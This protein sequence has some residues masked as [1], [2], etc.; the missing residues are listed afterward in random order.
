MRAHLKKI[1]N[2]VNSDNVIGVDLG[3]TSTVIYVKGKGIQLREPSVVSVIKE[4]G[5]NIPYLFGQ[6]AEDMYGKTPMNITVIKPMQDGVIAD[7]TMAQKMIEHFIQKAKAVSNILQKPTIIISVPF[8][9]T[10]VEINTIQSAAERTGAKEVFLI[11][12][13]IAAA[14]G[15]GLRIND[16]VGSVVVDIGGGTTEVTALSLG[17]IVC[18]NAIKVAGNAIKSAIIEY[19]KQ[20]NGI[21]I[22]DGMAEKIKR[23]IGVAYLK[24]NEENTKI[25]AMGR[26][27]KDGS[28][29]T[30]SISKSD[31]A[32]ALAESVAKIVDVIKLTLESTPPE[33]SV[34]IVDRGIMLTGGGVLLKNLDYVISKAVKLPVFTTPRTLDAVV[35]GIGV[36]CEN[37]KGYSHILFKQS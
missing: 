2:L 13:S 18:G 32:E 35:R 23:D 8:G 33:L 22:G 14:I 25:R 31:V 20:S 27:I 1:I 11:Y 17:G 29:T 21:L 37:V 34:D 4:N 26:S 3:T 9:A 5:V 30:F 36:V 24:K 19:V 12:E 6:K 7:M 10:P 16:P 28:P 15:S